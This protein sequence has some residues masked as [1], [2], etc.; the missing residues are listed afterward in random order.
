[1][2]LTIK[3]YVKE[4]YE[5]ATEKWHRHEGGSVLVTALL[6]IPI[7]WAISLGF[8]ISFR[9]EAGWYFLAFLGIWFLL[10]LFFAAP[11]LVW[12]KNRKKIFELEEAAEPKL[13]ASYNDSESYRKLIVFEE[14]RSGAPPIETQGLSIRGRVESLGKLSVKNCSAILTNLEIL[15]EDGQFQSCGFHDSVKLPWALEEPHEFDP[16][17]IKP[18]VP[19]YF[20][21]AITHE[22]RSFFSSKAQVVSL[23][24]PLNFT[25]PGT[26]KFTVQITGDDVVTVPLVLRIIWDGRWDN[27]QASSEV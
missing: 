23:A 11:F 17:T 12:Q 9:D 4:I 19:K 24:R 18:R 7:M 22:N 2:D 26:Y 16:I 21:V 25:E 3:A 8:P 27:I 10:L 20:G 5:V 13:R 15:G 14:D 6:A 1:M